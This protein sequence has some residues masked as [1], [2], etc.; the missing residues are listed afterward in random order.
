MAACGVDDDQ[1]HRLLLAN[2]VYF[3]E[4]QIFELVKVEN[5][6]GVGW[7]FL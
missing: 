6:L 7:H 5:Q 2:F 4:V 1:L 3:Q